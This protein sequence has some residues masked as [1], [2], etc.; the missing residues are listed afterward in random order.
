MANQ[1]VVEVQ[2]LGQIKGLAQ[3]I[4]NGEIVVLR[5]CLQQAGLYDGI[6]QAS[7]DGI[8]SVVGA[9]KAAAVARDGFD[10]IHESVTPSEI[11]PVTDAI[12]KAIT[13]R[14]HADLNALVPRIFP[15]ASHYYF[16]RSPNVRFHLPY[17]V[18]ADYQRAFKDFTHKRGE[19]KI[20]AHGPHRDPWVDCPVNVI[21]VWIAI[22]P[23]Q[24][25]NGL[26]VFADEYQKEFGF[27]DGYINEGIRLKQPLTFDL[28]P[29]DAVLFHSDH[30]HGSEL[31]RTDR[32]RYV[33]SYRV[34]LEKPVYPHGHYHQYLHAGL[35]SGPL[36]VLA[37][38]P[39]N[40]QWSFFRYQLRRLQYRLTG[41][42]RMTGHDEV[43]SHG[44]PGPDTVVESSQIRLSDFPIGAIRAT[45]K[46]VCVARLG[47]NEFVAV[48]R[49]CAHMGG[50]LAGGWVEDGHI[51]CPLHAL[52]YDPATGA[53]PCRSIKPLRRFPVEVRDDLVSVRTDAAG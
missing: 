29:G 31:N 32:T 24:R 40:L 26:T 49:R 47:E 22:G 2:T 51:V 43:G 30:L 17:D 7:V 21:N 3:R 37:G 34:S 33:I 52:P 11:P 14:A 45:S 41:R 35:A 9:D 39:Q 23:V 25:G 5:R 44:G 13:A 46:N 20:T 38:V 50:D 10:R 1:P 27:K 19:G 53:S 8:R 28:Q 4:L 36:R 48:S 15:E 6:S 42:G 18:V 12:Y 16:E